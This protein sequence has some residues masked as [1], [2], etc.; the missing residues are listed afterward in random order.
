M[1]RRVSAY[2]LSEPRRGSSRS[3]SRF[4]PRPPSAATSRSRSSSSPMKTHVA[5]AVVAGLLASQAGADTLFLKSGRTLKIRT[6]MCDPVA[7]LA[8]IEGGQVE[9]RAEDVLRVEGDEIVDPEPLASAGK[10]AATV[11]PVDPSRDLESLIAEASRKYA[12]PVSLVRAVAR[13]ES[14]MNPR[15]VSHKGASGVMQLMPATAAD[16]GVDDVFDAAQNIDA[17]VRLLRQHLEKYDGR[18]AE[19]LAAY[20]AGPG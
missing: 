4:S 5:G 20:N 10:T 6:L 18:V 19:A 3:M 17:G 2:R 13:T 1:A 11:G 7:C 9:L 14:A 16:L 15:V 8:G 12:L